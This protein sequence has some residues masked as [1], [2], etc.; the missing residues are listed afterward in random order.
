MR[1]ELKEILKKA[2]KCG[3]YPVMFLDLDIGG[4]LTEKLNNANHHFTILLYI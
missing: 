3:I 1:P 2:K 4:V